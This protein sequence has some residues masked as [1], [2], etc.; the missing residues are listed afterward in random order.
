LIETAGEWFSR[1]LAGYARQRILA[2]IHSDFKVYGSGRRLYR[3]KVT[4]IEAYPVSM[5]LS[6]PFATSLGQ[7]PSQKGHVIVAVET[8][9]GIQ[10]FGEAAPD[11]IYHGESQETILQVIE[12]YLAP[13]LIGADPFDFENILEK[14]N[15]SIVGNPYACAAIDL[16]LYDI[17]GKKTGLPA[18]KLLGGRVRDR[19]PVVFVLSLAK[20]IE[21]IASEAED[22]VKRGYKTLKIKVGVDPGLDLERVGVVREKVG[23]SVD[24]R[25]DANQGWTPDIAIKLIKKMERYDLQ[26][27]EQPVLGWDLEGMA[28]VTKAVDTPVMADESVFSPQMALRVVKM[29]AADIINIKIMKPGGL[30]NSKKI[31][32]IAEAADIPCVVGSM[33][34]TGIGTAAGA[35]FASANRI[36]EYPCEMIGPAYFKT[37]VIKE[38]IKPKDGFVSVPS[39]PGLGITPNIDVIKKLS[40][41]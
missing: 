26:L 4:R 31:A 39:K 33:L 3:M 15:R 38:D 10:G 30:Y 16:A 6:M 23:D 8:D 29:E 25:V 36:V 20:K 37:D 7:L 5:P 9:E 24:I 2:Q 17:M 27:V 41:T 28:R 32:S 1:V 11:P 22:C 14:E 40:P 35:H 13:S 18:C 19:I 12:K 34:E 21:D